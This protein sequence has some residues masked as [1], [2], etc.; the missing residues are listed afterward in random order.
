MKIRKV[1]EKNYFYDEI[2]IY[3]LTTFQYCIH[4]SVENIVMNIE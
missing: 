2:R 1:K 4:L 3:L